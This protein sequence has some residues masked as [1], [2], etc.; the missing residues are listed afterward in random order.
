M[1]APPNQ[2]IPRTGVTA[3]ARASAVAFPPAVQTP[4]RNPQVPELEVFKRLH[5]FR[6][7]EY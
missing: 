6:V 1:T 7:N 2:A 3:T 5:P 4:H